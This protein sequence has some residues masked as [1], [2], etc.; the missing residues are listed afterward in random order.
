MIERSGVHPLTCLT[1]LTDGEKRRF[2]DNNIV[3]CSAI[4]KGEHLLKEFGVSPKKIPEVLE[5][6]ERLCRTRA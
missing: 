5:E 2:L 4:R 6:T 1:T 3:L